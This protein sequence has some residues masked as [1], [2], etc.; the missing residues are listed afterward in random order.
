MVG[1][2]QQSRVRQQSRSSR[3]SPLP[4][5]LPPEPPSLAPPPS[6]ETSWEQRLEALRERIM[7]K[8][9]RGR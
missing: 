9:S 7:R 4:P 5:S 6:S 8:E 3:G 2:Q 1:T